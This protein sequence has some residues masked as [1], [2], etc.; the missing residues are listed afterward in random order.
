MTEEEW[1]TGTD[2]R[3]M[4]GYLRG[5]L[6]D[7][8]ARLFAV[9]C[10][11]LVSHLFSEDSYKDA[12]EVAERFA[13]GLASDDDRSDTWGSVDEQISLSERERNASWW[14]DSAAEWAVSGFDRPGYWY[15][16][17]AIVSRFVITAAPESL[18]AQL[19]LFHCV[20]GNPF[21]PVTFDPRWRTAD[22]VGL[23]RTIYDGRLFDRIPVLMDAL[24]DA[25][26][27]S[28]D[29][30]EHCRNDGPHVRGCWV[31][32]LILGRE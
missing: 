10:C 5:R 13:D 8:K 27:D 30:L 9:A 2:P 19:S 3:P 24:L 1:L 17:A 25:G 20:V 31:V 28:A 12:V 16:A 32:D 29:V 14:A 6:S 4:I 23:A 7:R 18:S 15:K 26:C 21:R 22:V 11:R